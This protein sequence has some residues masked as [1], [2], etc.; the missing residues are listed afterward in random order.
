VKLRVAR[1]EGAGAPT[2]EGLRARL[3]AAR[4]AAAEWADPPGRA[5]EP[6]AH[7]HDE[8]IAL[9]R[10]GITFEIAEVEYPLAPG[11]ILYLPAGTVHAAHAHPAEGATYLIGTRG[12]SRRAT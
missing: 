2:A 6:H 1:W 3:R 7:E 5:Y 11:D 12:R 4:C 8:L 10:G 9:V